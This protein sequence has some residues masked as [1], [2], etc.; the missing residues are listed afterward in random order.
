M[1][2]YEFN[3]LRLYY[4]FYIGVGVGVGEVIEI[5]DVVYILN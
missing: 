3:F 1:R 4:Y 2:W 5:K